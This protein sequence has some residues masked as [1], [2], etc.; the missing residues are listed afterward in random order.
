M[1][2]PLR[3]ENLSQRYLYIFLDEGGNLDFSPTGTKY[4]ILTSLTKERPFEAYK[5]LAELKYDI[6]ELG[7][8]IEY[9]HASENAQP[10]RNRVFD[11]IENHLEGTRVDSLVVEKRK[12]G[13]ALRAVERFYPEMLGYLLKYVMEGMK[14]GV[15]KEILVFTDSLPVRRK[16]EAI[17]KAIKKTLSKKL[18]AGIRYRIFHHESK[19]NM[20]LQIAD[21][22][23][24]AIYRKWDLQD[25]RSYS[26]IKAVIQS[27][28]DIFQIGTNFY[29]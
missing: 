5:P 3:A 16:R 23:T 27:E 1:T 9:F 18:P 7:T 21:Y 6:I 12:V 10:I 17:E 15:Y 22:C 4:F 13:P 11:I 24:W 28:Y 26:R 29:Y 19:S 25:E 20:D 2:Q 14:H 8:D